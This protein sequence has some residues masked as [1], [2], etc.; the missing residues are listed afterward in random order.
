MIV[1]IDIF[2]DVSS[3]EVLLVM[4]FVQQFI[5]QMCVQDMYGIWDGKSDL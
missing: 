3:D 4:F 1:S 5:K 2:S